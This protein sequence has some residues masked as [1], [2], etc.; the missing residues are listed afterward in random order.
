MIRKQITGLPPRSGG[1]IPDPYVALVVDLIEDAIKCV[2]GRRRS[3]ARDR[4]NCKQFLQSEKCARWCDYIGF[5]WSAYLPLLKLDDEGDAPDG[6]YPQPPAGRAAALA[7]VIRTQ[8]APL[9][10]MPVRELSSRT[11]HDSRKLHRW[12]QEG[13]LKK[14]TVGRGKRRRSTIVEPGERMKQYEY[15]EEAR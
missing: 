13:W 15:D 5:D 2:L 14:E 11:G 7:F 3:T 6:G 1:E 10:P 9:L 8:I 12:C 4:W